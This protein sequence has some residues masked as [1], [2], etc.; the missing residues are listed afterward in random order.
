MQV[1]E[2]LALATTPSEGV[3][4]GHNHSGVSSESPTPFGPPLLLSIR[5]FKVEL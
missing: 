4:R 5:D 1:Y 2:A 3:G